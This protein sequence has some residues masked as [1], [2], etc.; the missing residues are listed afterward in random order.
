[1]RAP[2]ST[3]WPTKC[4]ISKEEMWGNLRVRLTY[5]SAVFGLRGRCA[6]LTPAKRRVLASTIARKASWPRARCCC[7]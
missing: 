4:L 3:A 1:M 2:S 6:G 5:Q 7:R